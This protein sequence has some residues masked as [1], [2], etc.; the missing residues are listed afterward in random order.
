MKTNSQKLYE[1]ICTLMGKESLSDDEIHKIA[2]F[3]QRRLGQAGDTADLGIRQLVNV[4]SQL[5]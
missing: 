2:L 5:T 1:Q 4:D 3:L